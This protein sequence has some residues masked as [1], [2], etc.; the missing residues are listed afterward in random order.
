MAKE[1]GAD[2]SVSEPKTRKMRAFVASAWENVTRGGKKLINIR[3]SNGYEVIVKTPE[4][5]SFSFV[6]GKDENGLQL[7]ENPKREGKDS[8]PD[9][10][11][12]F[13]LPE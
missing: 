13:V 11:M 9:L 7:W 5:K 12:S 4:G 2:T 10:R 8:D 1:I 6:S 3:I